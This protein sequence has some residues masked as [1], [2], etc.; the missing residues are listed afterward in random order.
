MDI[1]V[2]IDVV[3]MDFINI[4]YITALEPNCPNCAALT[5][6]EVKAD[7]SQNSDLDMCAK[8]FYWWKSKKMCHNVWTYYFEQKLLEIKFFF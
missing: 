1:L 2:I 7:D 4:S 6:H 5:W 8:L 3:L